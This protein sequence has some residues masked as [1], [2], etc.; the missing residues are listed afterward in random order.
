MLA[1]SDAVI[2]TAASAAD[3]LELLPDRRPNL[4]VSDIGMPHMDGYEFIRAVRSLPFDKGGDTP[5]IALTA[6]ARSEDRRRALMAG[7]QMHVAKPVEPAE[8]LAVC[9]SLAGMIRTRAESGKLLP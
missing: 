7:F 8:L 3:G 6:F 5:A 2:L 9:A 4:L 1:A